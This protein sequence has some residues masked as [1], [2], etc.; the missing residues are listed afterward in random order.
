[1]TAK[2]QCITV[3]SIDNDRYFTTRARCTILHFMIVV[4]CFEITLILTGVANV[5]LYLIYGL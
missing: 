2:R 1:M 3:P 5:R 4:I